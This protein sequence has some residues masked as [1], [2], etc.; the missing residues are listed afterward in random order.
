MLGQEFGTEKAWNVFDD[1]ASNEFVIPNK[2]PV[3]FLILEPAER[4]NVHIL[5]NNKFILL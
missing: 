2:S 1:A 5:L 3:K 4:T